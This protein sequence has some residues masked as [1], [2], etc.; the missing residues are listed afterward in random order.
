MEPTDFSCFYSMLRE[1]FH[2]TWR[3]PGGGKMGACWDPLPVAVCPVKS[4]E[5]ALT[6]PAGFGQG[7]LPEQ[8]QELHPA[9]GCCPLRLLELTCMKCFPGNA[10]RGDGPFSWMR[11]PRK[12]RLVVAARPVLPIAKIVGAGQL[13]C[14]LGVEHILAEGL[15]PGLWLLTP[16]LVA[17]LVGAAVASSWLVGSSNYGSRHLFGKDSAGVAKGLRSPGDSCLLWFGLCCSDV[18]PAQP[19]VWYVSTSTDVR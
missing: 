4:W 13:W 11:Q 14:P 3:A 19:R 10:S 15:A 1:A 9:A 7:M 16:A 8:R 18:Y 12:C 5:M 2:W 17:T 6:L